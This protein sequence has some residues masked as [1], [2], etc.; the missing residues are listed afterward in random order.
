MKNT[1]SFLS[2]L[3]PIIAAASAGIPLPGSAQPAEVEAE[4]MQLL[5]RSTDYLAGM[6]QFRID[7][8]ATIEAVL[9]SGQ[10]I[11]YG[12]RVAITVQR[13]NKV[14]AE[15]IGELIN[16]TF[17]YD[18]KPLS[19][20]L[21]DLKYYAMAE[22]PATLESMLDFARDK[23]QIIAPG[24]DLIYKDAFE[25]LTQGLT[26][27]FV[28]GKSV[29]GGVRCDQIAFR[30]AEVDWQIWIQEGANPLPRKFVVTSSRIPSSPQF[31]VVMSKWDADPKI[32][33][34]TFKFAPPTGARRIEFLQPAVAVK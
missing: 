11:Q 5:R 27:A 33:D 16:Q 6:K 20:N 19:V 31:V 32:T 25:R 34:A 12:Q 26:S 18:G 13:P 3:L 21:P 8:D 29:I 22:A 28:V 30:N 2:C 4:A 1:T 17:Y 24:A 10:K 15:R 9:P 7:T 14:R 23:L